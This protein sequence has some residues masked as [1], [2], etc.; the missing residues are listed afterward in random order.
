MRM[1]E[2]QAARR[3]ARLISL[4]EGVQVMSDGKIR[5]Y[6]Y[7]QITDTSRRRLWRLMDQCP[8]LASN[9]AIHIWRRDQR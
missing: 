6:W 3:Y 4:P 7:N 8:Q 9:T 1:T 2:A 5:Y